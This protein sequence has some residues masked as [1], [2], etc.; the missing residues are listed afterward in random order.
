MTAR[1]RTATGDLRILGAAP[2][3]KCSY[4][5]FRDVPEPTLNRIF[6]LC[7][8]LRSPAPGAWRPATP[9]ERAHGGMTHVPE[10]AWVE[11]ALPGHPGAKL[12]R[13]GNFVAQMHVGPFTVTSQVCP[14]SFDVLREK[15]TPEVEVSVERRERPRGDAWIRRV[16]E[17]YDGNRYPGPTTVLAPRDGRCCALIFVPWTTAPS[18]AQIEYA[19]ALCDTYRAR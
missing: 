4:E 5:A 11:G 19:L 7:A 17:E 18:D 2:G 9:E 3:V 10:G 1:Y 16:I 6:M 8:S 15:S 13:P 14:Q 12:L